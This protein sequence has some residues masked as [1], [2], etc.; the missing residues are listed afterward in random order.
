M[1]L[2]FLLFLRP[3][4]SRESLAHL[5]HTIFK[6]IHTPNEY[7]RGKTILHNAFEFQPNTKK[8]N[9]QKNVPNECIYEYW[10][11][12]L[13]FLWHGIL[14]HFIKATSNGIAFLLNDSNAIIN[15]QYANGISFFLIWF[16][17]TLR[18]MQK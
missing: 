15:I 9:N 4:N 16:I 17:F 1:L 12:L 6:C 14:F 18:D 2:F 3:W 11:V 13:I 8:E 10:C 5:L 7:E